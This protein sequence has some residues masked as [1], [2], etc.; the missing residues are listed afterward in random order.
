MPRA[1]PL[2]FRSLHPALAGLLGAAAI[3]GCSVLPAEHIVPPSSIVL[4]LPEPA[5][6]LRAAD[7]SVVADPAVP[8]AVDPPGLLARLIWNDEFGERTIVFD[9]PSGTVK[10][11]Q[12]GSGSLMLKFGD[13]VVHVNP[14]SKAGDY[15]TLPKADQIWITD[16]SPEH[17]D[18]HAI[19]A[20]SKDSTLLIVDAMT[21]R[22]VQGLLTFVP[23]QA[24]VEI[25]VDDIQLMA[26]PTFRAEI[27]PDGPQLKSSNSYLATFGEF[28]L[29]LAGQAHFILGIQA[30]EQVDVALLSIDDLTSLSPEQAADITR[31]LD[32]IAV[33]PYQYGDDDPAKLADL[34][35]DSKT[36]VLPLNASAPDGPQP[37]GTPP[38]RDLIM[39]GLYL[40]NREPDPALLADLFEAQVRSNPLLL[41]DLMTL[42][43]SSLYITR[44]DSTDTSLLRLTNSVWNGGYGPLELW[45]RAQADA[46]THSVVQRIY[47]GDGNYEERAVG[48]F[49]FHPG[50]NHW[51]LDSF[52]LYELWSISENGT[53]DQVKATSDKV[54]YCL[55]DIHPNPHPHHAPRMVY[56]TCTYG[57]QGL[58]V[59]WV[60]VYDHYLPGQSIDI[61]GLPDGVYALISTADPYNLI[62]ESDETNNAAVIYLEIKDLRVAILDRPAASDS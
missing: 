41:P 4:S 32:P 7:Q 53:L 1:L 46:S 3:G 21:A 13:T 43:P 17:L 42:P 37:I 60:D 54:S 38:D 62:Q 6:P 39:S 36:M 22:R 40:E 25:A 61:S 19:R 57:R 30:I 16:P 15:E 5:A 59:G 24:G 51:H 9:T 23:L 49:I 56:G 44:D 35:S 14:W 45:G 8:L 58:S 18:L 28:R 10:L 27:S 11:R 47:L 55:R 50:H 34:L 48:E 20:V 31:V 12:V 26:L 52:S 29:F 33:L 2:P